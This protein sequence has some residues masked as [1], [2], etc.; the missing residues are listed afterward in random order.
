M[1]PTADAISEALRT[2]AKGPLTPIADPQIL[3][4]TPEAFA[5]VFLAASEISVA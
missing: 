2:V 1:E 3:R 5:A 4:E